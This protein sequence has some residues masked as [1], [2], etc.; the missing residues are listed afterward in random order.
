MGNKY[1]SFVCFVVTAVYVE[2]NS[3]DRF[4]KTLQLQSSTN[5]GINICAIVHFF[6]TVLNLR[7]ITCGLV[8]NPA[9]E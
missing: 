3:S 2:P 7:K 5:E 4:F 6:Y 8:L 1:Y 9:F